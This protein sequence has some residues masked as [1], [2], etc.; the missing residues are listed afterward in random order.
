MKQLVIVG[1]RG[2][3]REVCDLLENNKD[4]CRL[5]IGGEDFNSRS[6][7]IKGF[8]DDKV[9]A[10]DGKGCWPPIIGAVETYEIQP[11]DIFFC[12]LGDSHWR[13]Y[14]SEMF[15]RK[16]GH[17]LTVIH[18]TALVSPLASIGEGSLISAYSLIS[19][20]VIIGNQVI[21]QPFSNFGHDVR[22]GDYVSIESYVFLGGYSSVGELSTMHTKSSIV[23]HKSIG[24]ECVVGIGSVVMRNFKDG[25]KVFG[26]PALVLKV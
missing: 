19:S 13:K 15:G 3:G 4:Q 25:L 17:F 20:N 7:L 1:A 26:N 16:G 2:Y 9:D 11:D 10:L 22:V 12:A 23:P 6:L 5:F 24:K 18:K 14:Y 21:I 8:L